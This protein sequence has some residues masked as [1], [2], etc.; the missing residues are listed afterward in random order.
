VRHPLPDASRAP[1]PGH[2]RRVAAALLDDGWQVAV[3]GAP[4]E[5][6][7]TAAVTPPGAVDLGGRTSLGELAALLHRAAC[8]VVGNTGPA[9][10]SAAVGT[11]VVALFSPVVPAARWRPWGVPFVLL[12]DQQAPCRSSRARECPVPGH[13][14]L[15]DV[16]PER[17]VQA[18]A[19]LAARREAVAS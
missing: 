10:L 2:A 19:S 4:A 1:D 14:C 6:A 16:P 5:R 18:V 8:V 13:P 15:S 17:V 7:L 9:H 12:G 3:T 11:G